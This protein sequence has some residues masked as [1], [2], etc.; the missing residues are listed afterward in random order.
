MELSALSG[1]TEYEPGDLTLTARAG[2][3]LSEI[4]SA[5]RANGQFLALDPFGAPDGTIGA[6]IA[7]GSYGPLGHAF[8]G[9]RDAAIGLEFVTGDGALVRGGG[10]VVKNV[11][12]FDLVRLIIGSWGTLGVVTDV[13]VRLRALPIADETLALAVPD[14]PDALAAHLAALRAAPLTPWAAELVNASLAHDLGLDARSTLLLRLAGNGD[15]VAAQQIAA[16]ALGDCATAASSIWSALSGFEN[17]QV[18]RVARDDS[19]GQGALPNAVV[20]SAA[21]DPHAQAVVRLSARPSQLARVWTHALTLAAACDGRAHATVGRGVAR[22]QLLGAVES[23]R[24]ALSTPFD[25]KLSYEQLPS[26]LW[27]DLAPPVAN[28]RLSRSLRAKF[29]PA[30]VLNPGILGSR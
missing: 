27:A 25:G 17:V 21:R 5:T 22:V 10:R 13:S 18:P 6:T 26:S 4:E 1:I 2:T 9:P 28:D 19:L 11:A 8:G 30:G 23:L 20:P 29:D 16:N 3:P 24:A 7:T 15:S 12:G 14:A